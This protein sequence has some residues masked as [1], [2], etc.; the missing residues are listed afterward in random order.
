MNKEAF[1]ESY[2]DTKKRI[3]SYSVLPIVLFDRSIKENYM[4][5]FDG[6]FW[7]KATFAGL[8]LYISNAIKK[9][10]IPT[11]KTANDVVIN[12]IQEN[13]FPI[14]SSEDANF[15][16][17]GI[18]FHY[19]DFG[20][21]GVIFLPFI[22]GYIF[23]YFVFIFYIRQNLPILALLGFMYF[24]MMYSIFTCYLIKPWVTFYIPILIYWARKLYKQNNYNIK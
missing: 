7:G 13:Y 12:Y 23:R 22:F 24:M 20:I 3:L 9:T 14:S 19:L 4:E 8:D 1:V 5:R 18:F 17:T 11:H 2:E 10:I 21:L 15:A 16:Y 6:P